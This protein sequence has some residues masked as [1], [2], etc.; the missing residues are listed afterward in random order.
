ML[1]S[2]QPMKNISRQINICLTI[3]IIIIMWFFSSYAM[4][5]KAANQFRR[6]DTGWGLSSNQIN[7]IFQ[8]SR[9][10]IWFATVSG[11]NRYDGYSFK[12]FKNIP[13]D[14]SSLPENSIHRIFEDH[15]GVLWLFT[16][17]NLFFYNPEKENFSLT[18]E[19]LQKNSPI[20]KTNISSLK[21][22]GDSVLW[23][24]DSEKGVYRYDIK[25]D[26]L[27]LLPLL[28]E[29]ASGLSSNQISDIAFDSK[30][31][32]YAT[33]FSGVIDIVDPNSLQVKES[34]D[35]G[36]ENELEGEQ[37]SYQLFIDR[38]DDLWLYSNK[39]G[40]G[41]L[42]INRSSGVS[43]HFGDD[44]Q[45]PNISN[46]IITGILE[47]NDGQIWIGTDHKGIS[48]IDKTDFSVAVIS[49]IPGDVTGLSNN[50]VTSLFKSNDGLIWVGTFKNG[51]NY[52]HK[53]L[54]QF[55]LYR[56]QPHEEKTLFNNDV[57][58]F[59]EDAQGNL[60]IGTNGDGL[61][62]FDRKQGTFRKYKNN[63]ANVNSLT[64]DVV[65][66]LCVD[67]KE[68]LWI[69]TY[70]GGLD[71]FVDG[72]FK[73]FRHHPRD[74]GTIADDRIWQILEDSSGRLWIG[75]LGG[76]LDLYDEATDSF[77]HHRSR[78]FNSVSSNYI[79]SL[80]EDQ[81]GNIWIGTSDGLNMLSVET[82]RFSHYTHDASDPK[83]LSNITVLSI[84]EDSKNRLW[85][86]TR[87]GLNLLNREDNSFTVYREE[88]GLPDHNIISIQDDGLGNLWI[89][90]LNGL[91]NLRKD[92]VSDDFNFRNFDLLDG[93]QG[94]EFNEHSYY[95]TAKGELIFGGAN[96]FNIFHPDQITAN[97]Y[98]FDVLL[99]DFK[100][101]N[102]S[103]GINEKIKGDIVLHKALNLTQEL[104]LKY[105]QN[106]FSIEFSALNYFHP[107]RTKFRYMLEGFNNEWIETDAANRVV[108]Y[109]N[110]NPGTYVFKVKASGSDGSWS[111]DKETHLTIVVIPP[112]YATGW[113]YGV[114]F[115][116]FVLLIVYL[117]FIIRRREEIKFVRQRELE[118][119]Q[120]QHEV[121]AMKLRFFTNISHE[122]RTPLTLILTPVERLIK[123]VVDETLRNQLITIQRNGKRLLHLVN[124]LLDFRKI[125]A[126]GVTLNYSEGDIIAFVKEVSNSFID[127][128]ESKSIQFVINSDINSLNMSFDTDKMEKIIV[129][130]LSNAFK[131]SKDD[132]IV[133]LSLSLDND[134][135]LLQM[136]FS[137][138]GV[139]IA[140]EH[141]EQVFERFF[142][143]ESS[144][145]SHS[146]SG[147]GLAITR[148]FVKAHGGTIRVESEV[149]KG[150][151]FILRFPVVLS[152]VS[153]ADKV[154]AELD[155]SNQEESVHKK[156]LPRLPVLLIVEDN[157]E[158][159][160]YLKNNLGGGYR[161]VEAS[162]GEEGFEKATSGLPDIIISDVMM[163]IMDGL[164]LCRK[165]KRDERTSHIPIILLT[166]KVSVEQEIEGLDAGADDYIT[167]PFN[168]EM[169]SLKI[170]K[171]LEMG[172]T[173]RK[174]LAQRHF[175]IEPGKIGITSLD[176]K[177]VK[178][179]ASLV[180]KNIS[181]PDFTVKKFSVDMG[182]SRGHLYNK[183]VELT[184]KTPI[185]FIR[186]MR[187]KRAAQYL[188]KS[189]LSI[190]EIAFKVGFNEPKYFSKY[191]KEE[192]GTSP[193]EYIKK[194][195]REV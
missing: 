162:N 31:N 99:T 191:F 43:R 101:L 169:L 71:C 40:G 168:Y 61:V 50:S 175:E 49:T 52:Y 26:V 133:T 135:S 10:F 89:A 148:E 121:D 46:S 73:H 24:G 64:N 47:D 36:F 174:K 32:I 192:Y 111:N 160:L 166:A 102:K 155:Q 30:K 18:H 172:E 90:T 159:R 85:V 91:S 104:S 145:K 20:T 109:T 153:K 39:N 125:E 122:F 15:L 84:I 23:L 3:I 57:N 86:G 132:G 29:S 130:L 143:V 74:P 7:T 38:D 139:G 161:I 92:S 77:I 79:L 5:Q 100:L 190:S 55:D 59:A 144:S 140:P 128:F 141:K 54:Y 123:N 78:D 34:I 156:G 2:I 4:S 69:G 35:T 194:S 157:A 75:T 108:T 183:M 146:G 137:D 67:S 117:A 171:L 181:N 65:V 45:I 80:T 186:L 6:I 48:V 182:I 9:G 93:L 17:N 115:I 163:P 103:V 68:R 53:N 51:I 184:G 16:S 142:Q 177:F 151:R 167:K 185:E 19:I 131:F 118:E 94:L 180:E 178:K 106:V 189:Q 147:I 62:Y 11:L 21:I 13:S 27:E 96:G 82:Q 44:V 164:E 70:Q 42:Y 33:S 124:Q 152:S 158:L 127:L 113:A 88:D 149:G 173:F 193:T 114:Y 136:I 12:V 83:S 120:R 22:D 105:N 25:S 188:E 165:L 66:S 60:W 56:S 81:E 107:E 95:K 170:R 37:P 119:H 116:L 8:D 134:K 129:N 110:L 154:V 63:P 112:F 76:G 126:M 179:A 72:K 87:N 1:K 97:Y 28:S 58:C 176:E 98:F 150:S 138:Q 195:F 187:L 41:V 14:P